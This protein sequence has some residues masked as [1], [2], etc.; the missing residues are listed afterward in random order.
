[1]W[2]HWSYLAFKAGVKQHESQDEKY[3]SKYNQT[4]PQFFNFF[5]I[6]I[7]KELHCMLLLYILFTM[8]V[9]PEFRED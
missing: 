9:L 7:S 8:E 6:F 2:I 4:F 5:L 1:M 3:C